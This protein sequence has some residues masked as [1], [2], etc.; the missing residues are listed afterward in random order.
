MRDGVNPWCKACNSANAR[1]YGAAHKKEISEKG[2]VF[3]RQNS[4]LVAAQKHAYGQKNKEKIAAKNRALRDVDPE[5]ARSAD[6]ERYARSGKENRKRYLEKNKVAIVEREAVYRK[7]NAE[8]LALR[9]KELRDP[10]REEANA[11]ARAAYA[12][13]PEHFRKKA[14]RSHFVNRE[15][16]LSRSRKWH[17]K[18]TGTAHEKRKA[19]FKDNPHKNALYVSSRKTAKLNATPPWLT[20]EHFAYIEKVYA[21]SAF[22]TR[23]T[24]V[25]HH[26]DHVHALRGKGFCGLHVPWNLC[27]LTAKENTRKR[28]RLPEKHAHMAWGAAP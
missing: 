27:V 9:R 15:A 24:G 10:R 5:A 16:S 26:V 20:E 18:N 11:K 21:I 13:D 28:A 12:A 1:A 2:W 14:S 19:F 8:K 7:A 22:L 17:A 25:Q 4:E 23:K 3:R 6:R